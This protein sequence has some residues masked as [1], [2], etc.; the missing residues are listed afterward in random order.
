MKQLTLDELQ[1]HC[2]DVSIPKGIDEITNKSNY[3]VYILTFNEKAIVLGHGKKNRASV[4]FD[5]KDNITSNHFKALLVRLYHLFGNGQFERYIIKCK[6]KEEA[7]KV[8]KNLHNIFGGNTKNIP[9]EIE[10]K[11]FESIDKKS[12]THLVL[13]MAL[14]S[15][16]DGLSD[17]YKWHNAG[18]LNDVI[19]DEI[20]QRLQLSAT[21]P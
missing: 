14:M 13:K 6:D 16:F 15:S 19:W 18:I 9:P 11:L 21:C 10:E 5:D 17:L 8:E 3:M 2:L 1:K 7:K 12:V 4:I 20:S